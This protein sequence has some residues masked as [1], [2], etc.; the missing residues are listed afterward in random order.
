[1]IFAALSEAMQ[2]GEL[3][4]R[5]GGLCHW[6]RRKDGVVVIRE[7]LVL[8]S[9]RRAGLGRSM[10]DEARTSSPGYT[11]VVAKCPAAYESGNA[12]WAGMGFTKTGEKDGVNVWQRFA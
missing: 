1:M 7:I 5:Q 11:A 2:K 6:H 4:L 3:I 9:M 10:L 8:P 12:F